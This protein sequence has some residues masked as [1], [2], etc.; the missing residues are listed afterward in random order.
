MKFGSDRLQ[1]TA[2]FSI[3]THIAI[4]QSLRARVSPLLANLACV[5]GSKS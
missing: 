4:R 5:L 1:A 3:K 2:K